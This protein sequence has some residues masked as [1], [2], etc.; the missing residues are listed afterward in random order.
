[1]KKPSSLSFRGVRHSYWRTTRNLASPWFPERDSSPAGRDR[2]DPSADGF[3]MV[4]QHPGRV[5][6]AGPKGRKTSF[7]QMDSKSLL[8][9]E[10]GRA[11]F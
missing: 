1:M 3:I 2:N 5:S 8:G 11:I 9:R 6:Q 4:Y 10:R 7:S